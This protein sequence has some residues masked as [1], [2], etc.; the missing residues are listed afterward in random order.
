MLQNAEISNFFQII[1]K[2][3]LSGLVATRLSLIMGYSVTLIWSTREYFFK[4]FSINAVNITCMKIKKTK[5]PK[6]TS[7]G[8]S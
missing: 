6:T 1:S 4:L 2:E 8:N 7:H 3:S 5:Y